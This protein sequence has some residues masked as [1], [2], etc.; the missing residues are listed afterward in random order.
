MLYSK[1][2]RLYEH[3]F[4]DEIKAEDYYNDT[5]EFNNNYSEYQGLGNGD[6][7]SR[8]T[9]TKP[10]KNFGYRIVKPV[11]KSRNSDKLT[12]RNRIVRAYEESRELKTKSGESK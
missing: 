2:P 6:N 7:R 1:N 10:F 11:D 5:T 4:W 12:E 9:I 8:D 3:R